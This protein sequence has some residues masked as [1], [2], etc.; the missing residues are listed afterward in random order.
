MMPRILRKCQW[1]RLFLTALMGYGVFYLS[2]TKSEPIRPPHYSYSLGDDA[3]GSPGW[4]PVSLWRQSSLLDIVIP[5]RYQSNKW[6]YREISNQKATGLGAV[7]G[8]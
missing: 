3:Y 2:G 7:A 6:R 8:P 1:R 5:P 4:D